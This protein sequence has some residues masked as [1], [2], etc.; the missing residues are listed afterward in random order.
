MENNQG[1]VIPVDISSEMK[2]CY[3]EYSM[4][5]IVGRALPDIRDGLKPVHR[6]ILYSM[7]SLSLYPDKPYRKSAKIV[8]DVLANF[9]PH[10]DVS[11][12]D[13]LVRMAQDFSMR[14]PLINGHGNFGSIDGDSAAAMRY[15][16]A[17]MNSITVEMIRDINKD[18][19]DFMD[20]YDGSEKE[21]LVLPS[22]F[23]NLLV[24]GSSGIAV[25]MAT[26]I[27]PHNLKEVID[28]VIHI[29]DNGFDNT[30]NDDLMNYIKGPDFPLGG[31][32]I[33]N[34]GIKEA[35][36]KG[37]GKV[38]IRSKV[39]IEE[40]NGRNNIIVTE[41]PYQV[42]KSRLIEHIAELIRDK[43]IIGI[44]D[45]RDESDRDGIRIVIELKKD[46]NPNVLLN[47]LYK[48]TKLQD[49]FGII[50]L[51]LVENE[52]KI[53]SLKEILN[54]YLIHQK[55]VVTRR[56]KYDLDKAEQRKHILEGYKIA[57]DNIDE[58]I[59]IIKS[60]KSTEIARSTLISR[61]S[62]TE[63]QANSILEMRLRR[64]TAL[65]RNNI[66]EELNEKINLINKLRNI[67]ESEVVLLNL[68]KEELT[69]V[70][71]K[72]GDDRRTYIDILSSDKDV[73]KDDLIQKE[74][75]VITLTHDGYIKR[76]LSN[77]YS[78]Q[79][80]GGRGVQAM[81]VKENDF[82]KNIFYTTTHHNL[83]FFTNLGRVY[84]IKAYEIPDA[85]RVAKG[86]NIV[87]LIQL[88]V[89]E[90]VQA[91]L[92]LQNLSEEGYI[93]MATKHGLIKKTKI[94]EFLKIRK[95]GLIAI[96]IKEGD[97]LLNVKQTR[98]DAKIVMVTSEGYAIVFSEKNIRSMGRNATGVKAITLRNNDSLIALDIATDGEDLMIISENGYGK[99]TGLKFYPVQNRGGK[100]IKTYKI[101]DKTGKV[102]CATVVNENNDIMLV[103]SNGIGIR[104][105]TEDVSK[106]GR[107][108]LGVK[109]M[110][111][112][113]N[114]KV[115]TVGKIKD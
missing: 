99:R 85:S 48:L 35:Y 73:E 39:L 110:K 75:I 88:G 80:R 46:A 109:L 6:R 12:Y 19:V 57:L 2:K 98:G 17:K 15:T 107:S 72:Y 91:V 104:I 44:S 65:E 5:V 20:N 76:M 70:K 51:A 41:I 18:T 11:V 50:M 67:L 89:G 78:S 23:P 114:E 64:L 60:S 33:G 103:N 101:T 82:I 69:Y 45:L 113:V 90:K 1:K 43:K 62:L 97:E 42:N 31:V 74:D 63:I 40:I 29:I 92:C 10:G 68:I 47:Q 55:E 102:S 79:R 25:G 56:T 59:K 96:G 94:S 58:V 21:P 87:N 77:T 86:V 26:N 7:Y 71:N 37:R 28:G 3:M 106:I 105:K 93:L 16:E 24:N 115:I 14:N 84:N 27:P 100:G 52:P 83:L 111:T 22:R 54:Y 34:N 32:I 66:E 81:T 112:N 30:S 36:E 61:F 9:H 13:A 49:S 8:G 95:S 108:S 38:L 4:S 53:L